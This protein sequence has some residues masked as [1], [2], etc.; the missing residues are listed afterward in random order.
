VSTG[1]VGHSLADETDCAKQTM[2][3]RLCIALCNNVLVK[4]T[5]HHVT[6]VLCR[7]P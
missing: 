6:E 1:E 3:D 7:G 5:P 2:I 4:F